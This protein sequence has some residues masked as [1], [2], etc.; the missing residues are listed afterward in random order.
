MELSDLS[1]TSSVDNKWR[2]LLTTVNRLECLCQLK[3]RLVPGDALFFLRGT[4]DAAQTSEASKASSSSRTS[5]L[6]PS[7]P[8]FRE[9]WVNADK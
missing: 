2:H 8:W 9:L 4:A 1:I 5:D 3:K 6:P 7:T